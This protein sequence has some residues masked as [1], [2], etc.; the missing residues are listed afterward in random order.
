M[1]LYSLVEK[2]KNPIAKEYFFY[3]STKTHY[4]CR[5]LAEVLHQ[6]T[7]GEYPHNMFSWTNKKNIYIAPDKR[8]YPHNIFL[9]SPEKR[10]L[11]V[12][13]RSASVRRF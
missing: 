5:Y 1:Y 6:G 9:I 11:L 2:K 4:T 8:V 10:M 3:F 7:S 12:L 13:I